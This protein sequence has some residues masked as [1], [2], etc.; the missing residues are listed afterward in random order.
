MLLELTNID[1][2]NIKNLGFINIEKLSQKK[3]LELINEIMFW[4]GSDNRN[5]YSTNKEAIDFRYVINPFGLGLTT[6]DAP[7]GWWVK[8]KPPVAYADRGGFIWPGHETL[9]IN[10]EKFIPDKI[11]PV[12]QQA[13]DFYQAYL[14]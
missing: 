4:D 10:L 2:E 3:S 13:R 9:K 5:W 8:T 12:L 6:T 1:L 14:T 7:L 11:R